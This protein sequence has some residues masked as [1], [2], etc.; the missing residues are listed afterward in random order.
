[1]KLTDEL[2]KKIDNATSDEEVKT[3]LGD[4]RDGVE[5]VGIILNDEELDQVSGGAW[6]TLVDEAPT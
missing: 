6:T 3:I 4:A 2:R 1:M 5:E